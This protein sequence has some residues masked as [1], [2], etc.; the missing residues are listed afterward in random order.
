MRDIEHELVD[1]GTHLDTPSVDA[2]AVAAAVRAR[3]SAESTRD[4]TSRAETSHWR[5]RTLLVAAVV[6]VVALTAAMALSSSV[7]AAA[8]DLLRFAGVDVTWGQPAAPVVPDSPLP[9]TVELDLPQAQQAVDF[10]I[11]VP[12]VLA[13][14]ETIVVSDGGR[15]VSLLYDGRTPIRLDEF[16]GTLDPTFVKVT[17]VEAR[18]VDLG[19]TEGLWVPEPHDVIYRT[20]DGQV[21]EE[22]A[23]MSGQTLI[24]ETS[25]GV[26]LRLEGDLTLAEAARI[27]ASTD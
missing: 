26:T 1:L 10:P 6:L 20:E 19:H 5:G 13:E 4:R 2:G 21:L 8:G 27:A 14:P 3:L 24:W 7:R 15:V 9:S 16:D 23:R 22:T 12:G 17:L 11:G 25:D 18:H